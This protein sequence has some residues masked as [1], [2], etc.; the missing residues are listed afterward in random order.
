MVPASDVR[1]RGLHLLRDD[2]RL[3]TYVER[4]LGPLIAFD[5]QHGTDLLGALDAYLRHGGNK[6]AAA[7]A[8]CLSRPAFYDRLRR[9]ERV[10]GVEIAGSESQ[11]S[12][13]VAVLALEAVRET[14]TP[15]LGEEIVN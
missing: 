12:L 9:V 10:L 6:S 13:Y 11:L 7:E 14:G 15:R 8:V 1:V 2:F 4:E 3:Q 5:E